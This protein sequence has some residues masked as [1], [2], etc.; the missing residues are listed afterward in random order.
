[1]IAPISQRGA[2][3]IRLGGN[4]AYRPATASMATNGGQSGSAGWLLFLP[5]LATLRSRVRFPFIGLFGACLVQQV[6]RRLVQLKLRC[7]D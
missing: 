7:F 1:M 4:A 2:P 6:N 5:K 3:A